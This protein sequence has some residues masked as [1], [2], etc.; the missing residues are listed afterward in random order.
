MPLKKQKN[1]P[2]SYIDILSNDIE[3]HN[4]RN[5][6]SAKLISINGKGSLS[7]S[8]NKTWENRTISQIKLNNIPLIQ[9]NSP[10]CPTCESIIATGYGIEKAKCKELINISDKINSD[11]ISLNKSIDDL[12][13]LLLLLEKG[14]YVIADTIC[15]PTDGEGN[16][17][18]DVP[19]EPVECKATA[20]AHI[21]KTFEAVTGLPAFLYPTQ[22]TDCYNKE[23][24][25]YY[26]D[27][28]KEDDRH[29]PRAIV[30]NFSELISFII[31]GHHKACAATLAKKA[32]QMYNDYSVHR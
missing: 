9:I 7:V 19:D 13:P 17:F 11:F 18:W 5:L 25:K 31:D 3:I 29:L 32:S 20:V 14:L 10:A 15:Y 8:H 30:Y 28:F 22:N 4:M 21:P 6:K 23:R 1:K 27:R 16:F 26:A 24:V 12:K 2:S